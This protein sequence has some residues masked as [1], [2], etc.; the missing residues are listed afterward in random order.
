MS[1][2]VLSLDVFDLPALFHLTQ[3]LKPKGD[4]A[5]EPSV[6]TNFN[7]LLR[8]VNEARMQ[9]GMSEAQLRLAYAAHDSASMKQDAFLGALRASGVDAIERLPYTHCLVTEIGE[10]FYKS[11]R[12]SSV[13]PNVAYALGVL[14]GRA[15]AL[16]KIPECVI[17]TGVFDVAWALHDF[18]KNRGGKAMLVWPKMLLDSRWLSEKFFEESG[19]LFDDLEL[20]HRAER[21]WGVKMARE[22]SRTDGTAKL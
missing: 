5:P 4:A 16:A 13:A 10:A 17:V 19:V 22:R 6:R 7:E 18:V 11:R 9:K 8:C 1:D 15:Q 14:A 20:S 3:A 21:I 12:A 2:P